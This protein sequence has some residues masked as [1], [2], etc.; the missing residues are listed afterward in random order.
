MTI[1]ERLNEK[2]LGLVPVADGLLIDQGLAL[3]DEYTK[4]VGNSGEFQL[5]FAWGLY[6][7]LMS[8][9]LSEGDW[10][11]NWGDKT[12]IEKLISSIFNRFAPEENPLISQVVNFSNRW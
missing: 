7:I 9:N 6:A 2:L 4:D 8:P 1:S 12:A 10:S 3:N 11:R 5:A